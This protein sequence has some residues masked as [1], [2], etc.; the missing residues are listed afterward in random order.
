MLTRLRHLIF[1]ALI[2]FGLIAATD[3]PVPVAKEKRETISSLIIRLQSARLQAIGFRDQLTQANNTASQLEAELEKELAAAR[4]LDKVDKA[5]S[6]TANMTWQC[7]P[8]PAP[9]K[10]GKK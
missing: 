8:A 5:C 9:P 2:V 4:T 6:P 7:P 3:S 1:L 10:D